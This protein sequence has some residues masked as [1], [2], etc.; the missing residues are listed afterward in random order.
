M[1]RVRRNSDNPEADIGQSGARVF[2]IGRNNFSPRVNT[3]DR[4]Q[5][6]D[7]LTWASGQHALKAG[8]DVQFDG[9]RNDFPAYFSGSYTFRSLASFERGRPSGPGELYRQSFAGPGT[10]GSETQPDLR[11]Y[12]LFVQDDWKP[13]SDVT[14]S[15]GVRYDQ[16]TTNG[17]GVRNPDTDL[18]AAAIDTGRFPTDRNNFGPR[19]G[20]AWSPAQRPYVLRGGWGL[21]YGRTPMVMASAAAANNGLNTI[22]LA[23]TGEA[24]PAY[25]QKFTNIPTGAAATIPSIVYVDEDFANPR[26]MQANVAFEWELARQMTL[27]VTYLRVDGTDLPRSVDRNIGALGTRPITIAPAAQVVSVPF[28]ASARPFRRFQRVVAFESSAESSYN[29]LTLE[30]NRRWTDAMQFRLAYTLGKVV[31]TVPDA[32]AVLP[33]NP[34]DDAKYA[35]NPVDFDVDRTVGNN[36][37]RH[38]L[39]A[40]GVYGT[41]RLAGDLTGVAR[42]LANGWWVSAILTAQSGQSYSAR[43]NGDLNGD[44]NT[45]NDLPPGMQRNNLRFPA[46]VTLDPRIA[47]DIPLGRVKAQ[48]IWEAFNIF[49]RD[50]IN[51]MVAVQYSLTGT[52]LTPTADFGRPLTSAGERIMQLAVRLSF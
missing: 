17:S 34:G 45:S 18:S 36:D 49:N 35:S 43:V 6:A 26:L 11:E 20:I 12:S 21:F 13:R 16:M 44:G 38:R 52:T 47:R 19:L 48:I 37:Q 24:V 4:V 50:N 27:A 2:L 31:D 46:I 1:S 29:G 28:F 51:S 9:I 41:N 23:F 5:V 40:S 30:L 15:L 25:P 32:T 8:F 42:A 33:G 14:L 22:S 3:L 7:T 10:T 39:V